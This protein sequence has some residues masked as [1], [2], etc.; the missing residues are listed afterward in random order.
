MAK[1]T[2]FQKVLPALPRPFLEIL[3]RDYCGIDRP[4]QSDRKALE[5]TIMTRETVDALRSE[6]LDYIAHQLSV[7]RPRN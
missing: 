7:S 3:A 1:R 5:N 6:V 4:H 2:M